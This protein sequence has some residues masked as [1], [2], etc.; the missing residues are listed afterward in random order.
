MHRNVSSTVIKKI[1]IT[2]SSVSTA[3]SILNF[4]RSWSEHLVHLD[5]VL[6]ALTK[7]ELFCKLEKCELGSPLIKFLDHLLI[8]E[9]IQ[10]NPEKLETVSSWPCKELPSSSHWAV[11]W[12]HSPPISEVQ[13]GLPQCSDTQ[14][15]MRLVRITS[16]YPN[17]NFSHFGLP[18]SEIHRMTGLPPKIV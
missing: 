2:P 11:S 9:K 5:Q 14:S 7:E 16:W 8:G 15:I 13:Q 17:F 12:P 18:P 1:E 10:P 3:N 6:T 4:C